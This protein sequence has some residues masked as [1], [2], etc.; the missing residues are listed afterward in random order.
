MYE[1]ESFKG[2]TPSIA[3]VMAYMPTFSFRIEGASTSIEINRKK[4]VTKSST[5]IDKALA[6][7]ELNDMGNQTGA[8]LG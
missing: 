1:W 8:D 5:C 6:T 2:G 7:L 4:S 3:K